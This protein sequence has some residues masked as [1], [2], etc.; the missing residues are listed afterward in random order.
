MRNIWALFSACAGLVLA[1]SSSSWTPELS[2]KVQRAS[3]VTPSA[4]GKMAA[5]T[6]TS[7]I[8]EA[9]KSE[10]LTHI[11][12]WR[13]RGSAPLQLTRGEKSA[14]D[15]AFSPDARRLFFT[16][17]RS[18]KKNIYRIPLDGGEAEMIT[19]WKGAMGPYRLS[20]DGKWIAFTGAE[21]DQEEEK[22]RKEK[23]DL[24]VIDEKPKNHALWLVAV[25]PASSGKRPP[26]KLA[27]GNHHIGEFRWSPDGRRIAFAHR[28]SPDFDSARH[29]DL[30]EVE[31]ESGAVK[32]LAATP[33]TESQP[34]YSPD[35]RYLAFLKSPNTPSRIS[36]TRIALMDGAGNVRTL[37]PTPDEQPQLLDWSADSSRI[38][39]TEPK[40]TRTA[41]YAMP[42]D[43]PLA[44]V[45]E[46]ARGVAR[47]TD[48]SRDAI[49]A[50]AIAEDASTPAEA[51][52]LHLTSKERIQVSSANRDLSLP[53]VSETRVITW[54]AKDGQSMEGLLTFPAGYE[55]GKRYP[56]VL[57]IH[58]GPAG[59]FSESYT[60][61]AGVHPV[62]SLAAKGYAV[63]RCNIR[64]SSGYGLK[65]MASNVKD[66]GGGDYQDL[67]A[68][69][70]HVI[71]MGVADPERL[72]VMGWSY[73]GYMTA[74]VISQ[75][76]RFKAAVVGAGITNLWS[77]WGTND[78]PS[79]LD[80]YFSGTPWDE[81]DLYRARSGLFHAKRVK[82]PTLFLHGENDLRVPISQ[83][84]EYYHALKRLGVTTKMVAYPRMPHGPNEPKFQLDIMQRHLDWVEKYVK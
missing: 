3:D 7:A 42:V 8:L 68:G 43:G 9:E 30:S 54:R 81:P 83:A 46:P 6:Q 11:Y 31:V 12:L 52:L 73:G 28:P 77:M 48:L 4:D 24:K 47:V 64:G 45:Y 63:L 72:A 26:K 35:G 62:A 49:W 56:M 36:G 40:H 41:L 2:M 33:A 14:Q 70:D 19:D 23:R 84:Y 21:P 22:A 20:P 57:I 79:V 25:E 76:S 10:N 55:E 58:G 65:F 32:T 61:S 44:A 75:T 59:V 71:S 34:R 18:G 1:Q 66:W 67:M 51:C 16:S 5:W 60:G 29:A 17:E 27:S 38:Y 80:D 37:P 82:T 13:G 15:P 69:V 53:P 50:G 74:W 39:F 78:I